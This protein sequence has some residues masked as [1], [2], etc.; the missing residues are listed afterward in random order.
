[1]MIFIFV[2]FW[3]HLCFFQ[4]NNYKKTRTV[5]QQWKNPQRHDSFSER[6][7]RCETDARERSGKSHRKW[8]QV[9]MSQSERLW[10]HCCAFPLLAGARAKKS[11]KNFDLRAFF[12]VVEVVIAGKAW[13][14]RWRMLFLFRTSQ[15][16]C[17]QSEQNKTKL[18][19]WIGE[20][21]IK[22]KS[23]WVFAAFV[24]ARESFI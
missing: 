1:M 4:L 17:S 14:S 6:N 16:S 15:L 5:K 12:V 2:F 3:F 20:T 19:N 21:E 8:W 22:R 18:T 9:I 10:L 23:K 11:E 7:Q 13:Q 24:I